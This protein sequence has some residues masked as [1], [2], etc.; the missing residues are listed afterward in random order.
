[1]DRHAAERSS[2]L[3]RR[4]RA[5]LHLV[6]AEETTERELRALLHGIEG[7]LVG[8]PSARGVYTVELPVGASERERVEAIAA[9]LRGEPRVRNVAVAPGRSP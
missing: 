3:R 7:N 1:V 5:Q 8:G 2:R 9:R 4:D 6:L